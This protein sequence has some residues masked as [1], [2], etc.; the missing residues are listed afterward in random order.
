MSLRRALARPLLLALALAALLAPAARAE[1]QQ[2]NPPVTPKEQAFLVGA[3]QSNLFE[4]TTGR[5]A[6]RQGRAAIVRRLGRMFVRD[7]TLLQQQVA[8]VAQQLGVALPTTLR[9]DQQANVKRLQG[10]RGQRFDRAWLRIQIAAHRQALALGTSVALST[11]VREAVR[12]LG[13]VSGAVVAQHLGELLV[14]R[15]TYFCAAR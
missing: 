15:A 2:A 9:P 3:T 11:D 4:I 14:A 10:L 5:L 7:H 8:T 6:A 12:R 1:A 13:I